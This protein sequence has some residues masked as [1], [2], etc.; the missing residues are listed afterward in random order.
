[1]SYLCIM[2]ICNKCNT[3]KNND[4]FN[5]APRNL[6]GLYNTCK[7]CR[8]PLERESNLIYK[9]KNR[10]QI[11]KQKRAYYQRRMKDPLFQLKRRIRKRTYTSFRVNN[12]YK[13]KS[14]SVYLGTDYETFYNY[15]EKLFI[16]GMS[17]ERLNEIH[18]DHIIPLSSANTEEEL[19]KLCHYTNLQP[20]WA[21]DNLR[22]GSKI[23]LK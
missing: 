10:E 8:T 17:W 15:I 14:T 1:M 20:L 9:K 2:K 11:L 12:W 16:D 21:E 19:I 13:T 3:E 23:I 18:I 22:K 5:K 7:K 4:N 6:D